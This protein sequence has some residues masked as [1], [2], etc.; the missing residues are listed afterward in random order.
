MLRLLGYAAPPAILSPRLGGYKGRPCHFPNRPSP[1]HT[2]PKCMRSA[3]L[4]ELVGD[5]GSDS[6]GGAE[7]GESVSNG[8]GAK[9]PEKAAAKGAHHWRRRWR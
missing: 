9:G 2:A 5:D 6:G 3:M 4:V 8:G 1:H 7:G